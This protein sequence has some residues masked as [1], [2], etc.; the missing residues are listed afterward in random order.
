[1]TIEFRLDESRL[2]L[3]PEYQEKLR[4]R[5]ERPDLKWPDITTETE[6]EVWLDEINQYLC[7]IQARTFD[8]I[9]ENWAG[10]I[11]DIANHAPMM[12][13]VALRPFMSESLWDQWRAVGFPLDHD[14]FEFD[15][16]SKDQVDASSYDNDFRS[17]VR[18]G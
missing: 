5:R 8:Y 14:V 10:L 6:E 1:M 15:I 11:R 18:F 13:L 9:D 7:G 12:P 2:G 16:T 3:T 4:M 17:W